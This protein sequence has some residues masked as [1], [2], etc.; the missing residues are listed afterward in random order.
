MKKS[1]LYFATPFKKLPRRFFRDRWVHVIVFVFTTRIAWTWPLVV[2]A[3]NFTVNGFGFSSGGG[4]SMAGHYSVSST[5]GQPEAGFYQSE[6]YALEAG[7]MGV[8]GL[9]QMPNAPLLIMAS[10]E[11][12]MVIYW[13]APADGFVLEETGILGTSPLWAPVAYDHQTNG[14]HIAITIPDSVGNRFFRLHKP[15]P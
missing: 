9:V 7:L 11:A 12:G 6:T 13:P 14:T 8:Y 1:V 4:R 3:Q 2:H 10:S 5:I 15:T